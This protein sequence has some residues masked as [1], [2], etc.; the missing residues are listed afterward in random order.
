MT[1]NSRGFTTVLITLLVLLVIGAIGYLSFRNNKTSAP[2]SSLT[3]TSNPA[4]T[5]DSDVNQINI[6]DSYEHK[7]DYQLNNVSIEKDTLVLNVSYSGGCKDHTFDLI[8]K[9][10]NFFETNP[11]Q[12]DLF[13]I[14]NANNDNCEAYITKELKFD[15]T[16]IKDSA[17]QQYQLEEFIINVHDFNNLRQSIKYSLS[18]FVDQDQDSAFTCPQQKT[19]D[20]TP[21]TGARCPLSDPQYCHKGTPQYNW[22]IENCP[23]VEIINAT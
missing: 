9:G 12:A 14:H 18:E 17:L 10:G 15:L 20:C 1:Q 4:P 22:I 21:C 8:W 7:D 2:D 13:L 11:L 3:T 19:I 6:Q 16:P 5:S 23:D